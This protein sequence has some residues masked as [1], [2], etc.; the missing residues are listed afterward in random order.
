MQGNI[1]ANPLLPAI[2][3][4]STL[5]VLA[6][7]IGNGLKLLAFAAVWTATFRRLTASE[8][9]WF[10][11][12]CALFTVMDVMAVRQGVFRFARPDVAGLPAWEFF[13]WGFLVLHILRTI[14]GPVP[15]RNLR[16][17][18]P[19]AIAFAVPFATLSDMW[20]LLLV[21]AGLLAAALLV[22]HDPWDFKYVAYAVALGAA[23]EYV[24]VWSGQWAYPA[25][26][27]G[28][29]AFWFVTMWG[30]IGLFARRLVLPQVRAWQR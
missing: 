23:F 9:C 16:L 6:L 15:P 7:P 22:F 20:L 29:V 3:V 8:A 10:V 27:P 17:V 11:G 28:G 2:Q 24:G 30:G 25:N 18:L 21:S 14:D 19:L 12:V 26:P 13:M 1:T 4:V 5:I